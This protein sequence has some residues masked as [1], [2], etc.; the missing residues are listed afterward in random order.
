MRGKVVLSGMHSG[1]NPSPGL[2][3][4]RSLRHA[5][6]DCEILGLDY[7]PESSGLHTSL[8]DA[9]VLMPSW[10][11][12]ETDV[13]AQQVDDLLGPHDVF[14]S[15]LDLEVR[16]IAQSFDGRPE[17]LSPSTRTLKEVCKPPNEAARALEVGV[18]PSVTYAGNDEEIED[19]VR[20]SRAG[21]WV[22][23]QHYEAVR[24]G[25][26]PQVLAAGRH[27]ESLWGGPWHVERHVAG[28]EVGLAFA[29]RGGTLLG[30]VMMRKTVLTPTGKTWAGTVTPVDGA[31]LERLRSWVATTEWTG[32]GELELIEHWDQSLTLMEINPRF[33]AWIHGASLVSA[34]LPAALVLGAESAR[35]TASAGSFTRIVHEIAVR[36][37]IGAPSFPWSPSDYVPAATKHPSGMPAVARR[38]LL[39][40]RP[41]PPSQRGQVPPLIPSGDGELSRRHDLPRIDSLPSTPHL[42]LDPVAL[43]Q[44]VEMVRSLIDHHDVDLCYSIKTNPDA[45]LVAAA[46]GAGMLAEAISQ[47]ELGLARKAGATPSK[48]VLNGPA[49]WWPSPREPVEARAIFLDSVPEFDLVDDVLAAGTG[50]RADVVGLRLARTQMSSRF[51]V[52][53]DDVDEFTVAS[54]RLKALTA[55]LGSGWGVHFHATESALGVERWVEH[56][57][58]ALRGATVLARSMGRGP[59]L[60]DFGGG[61][62]SR[63]LQFLPEAMKAIS[64]NLRDD[65]DLEVPWL[66][67]F[68]KSILEPCG[69]LIT[70]VIVAPNA[71]GDVV[72]DAGLSDLPEGPYWPHPAGTLGPSGEHSMLHPG[73]GRILGR[74]C[75]ERDVLA[76]D[77][78]V[79]GLKRGDVV[80]LGRAG[81]YDASMAY[82][83]GRGRRAGVDA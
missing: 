74:T 40:H 21:V 51:G 24:A 20:N 62:H 3:I 52:R 54:R 66:F 63:D 15:S 56:C 83:F 12:I 39:H 46:L 16:L 9:P 43:L 79:T 25:T 6:L 23:G 28:Q 50:L 38:G 82:P 26:L 67:E 37:E 77:V 78:D 35:P 59:E 30:A 73:S 69:T 1:P 22:K 8:I 4:A 44:G 48:L 64:A 10:E 13:W 71:R 58:A 45:D 68:G 11:E 31:L 65:L 61:W 49:K 53:V 57:T 76:T 72:V 5:G 33:P 27:I 34:N 2:G 41:G 80:T 29:A 7:S 47:D 17:F 32:G 36:A 75:M 55:R 70:R 14:I 60:L 18:A 42:H 19:F 81:G